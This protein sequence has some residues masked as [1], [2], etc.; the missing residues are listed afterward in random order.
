MPGRT[1]ERL[2][3][4]LL[5]CAVFPVATTPGHAQVP[6]GQITGGQ[7]AGGQATAPSRPGSQRMHAVVVP[8]RR[9]DPGMRIRPPSMPPQSTPVI[10][11]PTTTPDGSTVVVPK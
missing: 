8:D 3:A 11:P 5:A 2:L 1:N 6:G 7:T 9:I 4:V 10:R